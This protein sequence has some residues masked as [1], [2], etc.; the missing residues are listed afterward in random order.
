MTLIDKY[1][2]PFSND[3]HSQ[4][5]YRNIFISITDSICLLDSFLSSFLHFIQF[6]SATSRLSIYREVGLLLGL[7]MCAIFYVLKNYIFMFHTFFISDDKDG[8]PRCLWKMRCVNLGFWESDKF[9][10][11][12]EESR[13]IFWVK[14]LKD[15][16][17]LN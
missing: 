2:L 13:N 6:F 9:K 4:V 1:L 15:F 10:K 5:I 12:K 17:F 11:I 3:S 8:S 14:K 16:Y 7:C